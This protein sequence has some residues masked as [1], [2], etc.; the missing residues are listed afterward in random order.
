MNSTPSTP[1]SP[2]SS[3]PSRKRQRSSSMVS[4]TSSSSIKRS[5]SSQD[6]DPIAAL[7]LSDPSTDADAYMADLDKDTLQFTPA[8][9]VAFLSVPPAEKMTRV[10]AARAQP[11]QLGS[12]WYLVDRTWWKRWRKACG[13]VVDKEG[14][15]TESELGPVDNAPL[16]NPQGHLRIPLSDG[17]DFELVPE[18]VWLDFVSW[19]GAPTY[20]LPR[21]VVQR[22]VMNEL[23]VELYPLRL[24]V[25]RMVSVRSLDDQETEPATVVVS[26]TSSIEEASKLLVASVRPSDVPE[27]GPRRIWRANKPPVLG[28]ETIEFLVDDYAR[29]ECEVFDMGPRT[30]DEMGIQQDD[31]FVVEFKGDQW[32]APTP[33]EKSVTIVG[34]VAPP[35]FP[36]NEGFFNKMGNSRAVGPKSSP[37]FTPR[38]TPIAGP[39]LKPIEPGTLG[40]GNM[41][42]TCFMNSALQCLAHQPELA[43]YFLTG[44]YQEELNPDNPLGMQGAIAEAFGD[45]LKRIWASTSTST[46][47]SPREFKSQL[48][49]FAPQFS[50][51]QQ[52]DSQE[53][54]AFLLDGLHED[55]N[56]VIKKPYVEKPDWEGGGDVELVQLAQKSWEGYMLRNDSVIVDLFQGQYQSTLVCPECNKI[57]I[58]FDP[59]MYLTLPLP[60]NKKWHHKI[61]YVPWDS[62]KP[63]LEIP[64]QVGV[65]A[66][67]RELRQLLGRWM[68]VPPEN[69][70]TLEVFSNKFYKSWDDT[71]LC[72]EV[73]STDQIVCFELPCNSQQ[74]R[75]YK[76]Q[77]GDPLI[78]PVYLA[79]LKTPTSARVGGG[80]F[81]GTSS[82]FGF[83]SIA[84]LSSEQ[85]SDPAAIYE[86]LVHRLVRW[87]KNTQDLFTWEH[88]SSKITTIPI[89]NGVPED[90][91]V[92]IKANGDVIEHPPEA[93][94]GD[95]TD[96]KSVIVADDDDVAMEEME[97]ELVRM[98]PK[99]ELFAIRIQADSK[100]YGTGAYSYN[101]RTLSLSTRAEEVKPGES[102]LKQ[103]DLIVCEFDENLKPFY[104]GELREKAQWDEWEL[105]EH[106]EVKAAREENHQKQKQGI[107]LQDC[108]D[109]F[110]KKEQLGEDDLWYCPKCKK[111]Q[112]ATKKF[113]LWKVPDI[114]VVHLK[115][116]SNSRTLRDKIDAPIDFPIEGL[117]LSSMVG[118]RAAAKRLMEAG[119]G[120]EGLELGNPDEPLIYDLFGVDEHIG[121]LGGG[122]YRAYALNHS[123]EKWYHFDDSYV[124]PSSADKSVNPNA[125]LLFYRRRTNKPLGGKTTE[126]IAVA[127]QQ[128]VVEP[129]TIAEPDAAAIEPHDDRDDLGMPELNSSFLSRIRSTATSSPSS[130][131][132]E[133]PDLEDPIEIMDP[134]E[135]ANANY[136]FPDPS[137]SKASPTSSTEADGGDAEDSWHS[138]HSPAWPSPLN[139]SSPAE[140]ASENPFISPRSY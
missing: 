131:H 120:L 29:Y 16:I 69:L 54:V 52:H 115:R 77:E 107:S 47:Y 123:N 139:M 8:S 3:Q 17:I 24:S 105:F 117:D 104:F 88:G 31:H 126:K 32:L 63:H 96:E 1:P 91:L 53:L 73:G 56:R 51:Y 119:V 19:Y 40:L 112:Q 100:E 70:L 79:D 26:A 38:F 111:H 98:G 95:I 80:T 5:L 66:S 108:L 114:L 41:G 135:R 64:V 92:E 39:P 81:Y 85:A 68:G 21:Q 9:T 30:L 83:P 46:S 11:L 37:T 58:T 129:T 67:F 76:K 33:P 132:D 130:L 72:G 25:L 15:L 99:A 14:P 84:V 44:V 133:P 118:E 109:E 94:E 78:L 23:S 55:L 61:Y 122:H 13:G 27:K 102:L 28:F 35:M 62:E 128:R 136:D 74:S 134:L 50:G 34:P 20:T 45:L 7:S 59:F 22:G 138:F 36:S 116:F 87:S 101:T 106:D 110:T 43:D 121:G 113:D 57:S 18:S 6:T 71:H 48:Q 4:D 75:T 125:Y 140:D 65:D 60:V 137:S 103:G 82:Y 42:N 86:A 12:S 97:P 90:S 49:R 124:T 93:P 10:D 127:R 2:S 89:P